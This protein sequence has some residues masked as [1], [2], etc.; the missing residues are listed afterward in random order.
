[1]V[2]FIL[3][4]T[5]DCLKIEDKNNRLFQRDDYQIICEGS[6]PKL[7]QLYRSMFT[8]KFRNHCDFGTFSLVYGPKSWAKI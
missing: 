2:L 1:M 7:R 4:M 5:E 8:K 3:R 6:N